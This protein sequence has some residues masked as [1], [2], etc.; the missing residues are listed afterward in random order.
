MSETSASA[1]AFASS[2]VIEGVNDVT[3][4]RRPE[5]V[6]VR[7]RGQAHHAASCSLQST[8]LLK[9]A[10]QFRAFAS[11]RGGQCGQTSQSSTRSPCHGG[12]SHLTNFSR[13]QNPEP[14]QKRWTY[15]RIVGDSSALGQLKAL[16][17]TIAPETQH[18]GSVG[19]IIIWV[20]MRRSQLDKPRLASLASLVPQW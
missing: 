12:T 2:R 1:S 8:K 20:S 3:V 9:L 10:G 11:V 17:P 6:H 16:G 7:N 14:K 15:L 19:W 4:C 13:V 18:R 5:V